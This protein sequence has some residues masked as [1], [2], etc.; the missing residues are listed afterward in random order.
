M[1][2]NQKE[3]VSEIQSKISFHFVTVF[4]STFTLLRHSA[5]TQN[6]KHFK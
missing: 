6:P 3:N 5:G 1:K 2:I 4:R